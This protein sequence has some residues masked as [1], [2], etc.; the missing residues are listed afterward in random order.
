M[1]LRVQWSG[2]RLGSGIRLGLGLGLGLGSKLGSGS[3]NR[4]RVNL[5]VAGPEDLVWGSLNDHSAVCHKGD[6][7]RHHLRLGLRVGL[8]LELGVGVG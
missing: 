1:S 7:M 2:N 3:G 4:A 6:L 5:W 8:R